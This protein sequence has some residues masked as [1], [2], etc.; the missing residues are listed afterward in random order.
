MATRSCLL[1][2][3]DYPYIVVGGETFAEIPWDEAFAR[4]YLGTF[5]KILLLG[6][7]REAA[8][9]P[10]GW[11]PIDERYY[12]VLDAGDWTSIPG[13]VRALPR[14]RQVLRGNWH[15][16]GVLYLK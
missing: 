12:E 1:V 9:A 2:V 7:R 13:F 6:R 4:P 5:E 11:V 15:R 14:L 16:I 3:A 10:S 8:A